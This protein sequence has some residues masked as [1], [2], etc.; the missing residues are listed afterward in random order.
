LGE[1]E[2]TRGLGKQKERIHWLREEQKKNLGNSSYLLNGSSETQDS[3]EL[4]VA[5]SQI[6][7]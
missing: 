6:F 5:G 4:L 3:Y 2:Y 7:D 1:N